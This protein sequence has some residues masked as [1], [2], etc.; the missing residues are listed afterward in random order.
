MQRVIHMEYNREKAIEY[1][2]KWAFF[3]N[4]N[5]ANFDE[6]GGDCTNFVSQC[7]LAGGAAMNTTPI[8]GWYYHSI[9]SRAPAW[10]GVEE[11][12]RFT[13]SKRRTGPVAEETGIEGIEPGD[14]VQLIA[15]GSR[16]HHS[17]VIVSAG[18]IPNL[19]NTQIACHTFDSDY[20]PLSTY[21]IRQIRFLH[22]L[23]V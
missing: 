11:L 5:F 18:N 23:S 12:Y 22:I 20:R 9:N 19:D 2:H 1:A 8:L 4:P 10:T 6:M 7:L 3:R 16:F 21:N 17:G 14:I 13:T 15:A